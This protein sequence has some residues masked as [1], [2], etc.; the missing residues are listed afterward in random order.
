MVSLCRKKYRGSLS[1]VRLDTCGSGRVRN[2]RWLFQ[3]A[4][5]CLNRISPGRF[6]RCQP[7]CQSDV[8]QFGNIKGADARNIIWQAFCYLV[9]QSSITAEKYVMLQPGRAGKQSG[10]LTLVRRILYTRNTRNNNNK[11]IVPGFLWPGNPVA[12]KS[13]TSITGQYSSV[14]VNKSK[15][16]IVKLNRC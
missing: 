13:H 9:P 1:L 6:C 15:I 12:G 7:A 3:C 4:R 14:L 2:P 5:W 16:S 11:L 8:N 10:K